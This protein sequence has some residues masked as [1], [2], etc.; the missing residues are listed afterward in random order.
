MTLIPNHTH[1]PLP[2]LPPTL[3]ANPLYS[4][5]AK[6]FMEIQSPRCLELSFSHGPYPTGSGCKALCN[7]YS[8]LEIPSF[9]AIVFTQV[10]I[11]PRM[12][13]E[14]QTSRQP[15][16]ARENRSLVPPACLWFSDELYEGSILKTDHDLFLRASNQTQTRSA[17]W[18]SRE[19]TLGS[20]TDRRK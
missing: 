5:L 10:P 17:D 18:E 1:S 2:S 8:G 12:N 19:C 20:Q 14:V 6:F 16:P 13:G 9:S 7:G 11:D 4:S 15:L 3:L